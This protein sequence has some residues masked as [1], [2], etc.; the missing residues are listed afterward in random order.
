MVDA[1]PSNSDEHLDSEIVLSNDACREASCRLGA[2]RR[3]GE[4][5]GLCPLNSDEHLESEIVRKLSVGCSNYNGIH[6]GHRETGTRIVA[7]RSQGLTSSISAIRNWSCTE[8]H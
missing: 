5:V 7:I 6:H 2:E 3:R 8:D 4:M 1:C